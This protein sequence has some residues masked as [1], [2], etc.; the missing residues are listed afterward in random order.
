MTFTRFPSAMDSPADDESTSSICASGRFFPE[1]DPPRWSLRFVRSSSGSAPAPGSASAGRIDADDG[2]GSAAGK[3]GGRPDSASLT[4]PT[5][6]GE[7]PTRSRACFFSCVKYFCPRMN[8]RAWLGFSSIVAM[9]RAWSSDTSK[10]VSSGSWAASSTAKYDASASLSGEGD[11]EDTGDE[12]LGGGC[13][14]ARG[15]DEADEERI[16]SPMC[17]KC[18]RGAWFPPTIVTS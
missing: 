18:D 14:D 16:W 13:D 15:M 12:E 17:E 2:G 7:P 8:S 3:T 1:L 10:D 11:F 9:R 6:S 4:L 5:S